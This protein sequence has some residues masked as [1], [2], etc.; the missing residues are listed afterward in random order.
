METKKNI[1]YLSF[2]L[3]VFQFT[4]CNSQI[5]TDT[6]L[7]KSSSPTDSLKMIFEM[8]TNN[9]TK[10][11]RISNVQL[12]HINLIFEPNLIKWQGKS[13][14]SI[15]SI[16]S[17][18]RDSLNEIYKND[19]ADLFKDYL[20]DNSWKVEY[21]NSDHYG[22]YEYRVLY[23]AVKESYEFYYVYTAHNIGMGDW[24]GKIYVLDEPLNDIENIDCNYDSLFSE[25]ISFINN[26]STIIH[27]NRCFIIHIYNEPEDY[28]LGNK[29][30]I[31][32]LSF[33]CEFGP[34]GTFNGYSCYDLMPIYFY[35]FLEKNGFSI[36]LLANYSLTGWIKH[37]YKATKK[38]K[39]ILYVFE[40]ETSTDHGYAK[41]TIIE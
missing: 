6:I 32:K 41:I 7:S 9:I 25:I 39:D 21:K 16:E 36:K 37:F 23:K 15:I 31:K 4:T 28:E 26:S 13:L 18:S 29:K 20:K 10:H 11:K 17:D 24:D 5:R 27:E 33:Y 12:K 34:S 38:N 3:M 14:R 35:D 40:S 8:I 22:E 1:L 19:L 30:Y 2:F